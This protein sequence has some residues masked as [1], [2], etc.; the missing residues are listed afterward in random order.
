M[1]SSNVRATVVWLTRSSFAIQENDAGY[2]QQR[3]DEGQESQDGSGAAR[4]YSSLPL[5]ALC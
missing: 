3:G 4:R 2:D 5:L 1:A